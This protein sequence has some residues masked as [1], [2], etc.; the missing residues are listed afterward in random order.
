VHGGNGRYPQVERPAAH[1]GADAS[2]LRQAALGDAEAAH[3]LE[4]RYDRRVQPLGRTLGL[5]QHAVDAQAH[6]ELGRERLKMDVRGAALQRGGDQLVDQ[7]DDRGVVGPFARVGRVV[8][9]GFI[10]RLRR[11]RQ[12]GHVRQAV[13]AFDGAAQVGRVR[14][15][16]LDVQAED[17]R[18]QIGALAGERIGHGDLEPE[19]GAAQR[20]HLMPHGEVTRHEPQQVGRDPRPRQVGGRQDGGGRCEHRSWQPPGTVSAG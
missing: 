12:F 17:V 1:L 4:P 8:G 18:Q 20:Q 16:G 3:D 10:G 6:A 5:V 14:P 19:T 11:G 13:M 9:T 7:A 2:V 15:H